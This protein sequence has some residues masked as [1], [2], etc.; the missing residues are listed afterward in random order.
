[1]LVTLTFDFITC[2]D[3]ENQHQGYRFSSLAKLQHLEHLELNTSALYKHGSALLGT[4]L[5]LAQA[6][7]ASAKL[8]K[9]HCSDYEDV[10]GLVQLVG[11]LF[12]SRP[13][14]REVKFCKFE[15]L[16]T[17]VDELLRDSSTGLHI[18][19]ATGVHGM[20]CITCTRKDLEVPQCSAG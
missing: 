13:V 10:S 9:F 18:E 8:L 16:K 20:S 2:G 14:L 6:L 19:R 1:M 4:G 3:A 11:S 5:D 17:W 12:R 7:P 15:F